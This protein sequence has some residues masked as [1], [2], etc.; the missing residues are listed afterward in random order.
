[1]SQKVTQPLHALKQLSTIIAFGASLDEVFQTALEQMVTFMGA[2]IGTIQLLQGGDRLDTV[3]VYGPIPAE[4]Y[5]VITTCTVNEVGL[6]PVL[7]SDRPHVLYDLTN[8]LKMSQSM[9]ALLHQQHF[10]TAVVI[11]LRVKGESI[12]T[13]SVGYQIPRQISR[14]RLAWFEAMTNLIS[15][16]LYNAQLLTDLHAKQAALQE[17]WKAVTD[18]QEM[19]RSRLSRELH[20]EVGQAL[21]SLMLRMKALQS[22]TDV[23]MIGDRLN[24]LRY[25][26]GKTLEEVRRISMDLH[27][28]VFDELGLI[29]AIRSYVRECATWA[30]VEITFEIRGTVVQLRPELEIACYRAVQESLTNIVRHAHADKACVV[31]AYGS[32]GVTLTVKD[33]G[34]G[35]PDAQPLPGIG[36]TGMRERIHL[37]GGTMEIVSNPGEGV[38][39]SIAFPNRV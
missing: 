7:A 29:P 23:E 8:T 22:E 39:L 25:L 2:D 21:T 26:T 31:L 17:A 33:N 6:Q 9:S 24:G 16:S 30:R 19:E 13:L 36:L 27:P 34:I 35:M 32:N 10:D 38:A 28:V 12:G 11:A 5:Q 20:D 1:M 3:A 18:V 14:T 15:V 37:V 4:M